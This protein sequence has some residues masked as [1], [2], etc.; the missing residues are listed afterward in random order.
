M[1]IESFMRLEK[2]N[3]SS[4]ALNVGISHF[5]V[6]IQP[7]IFFLNFLLSGYTQVDDLFNIKTS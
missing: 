6:C 2:D 4:L 1:T 3:F 5:E 7:L